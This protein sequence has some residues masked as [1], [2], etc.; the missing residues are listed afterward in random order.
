ME[1]RQVYIILNALKESK[2]PSI[3]DKTKEYLSQRQL[4]TAKSPPEYAAMLRDA[5]RYEQANKEM[6]DITDKIRLARRACEDL[7]E[8]AESIFHWL[9]TS[10]TNLKVEETQYKLH[11]SEYSELRQQER[12]L[13]KEIVKL[14]PTADHSKQHKYIETPAGYVAITS[15][16]K[17][18][19]ALLQ[20]NVDKLGDVT[21][22]DFVKQTNEL[23]AERRRSTIHHETTR[24]R[25]SDS[26]FNVEGAII[27]GIAGDLIDDGTINLSGGA[28]LGGLIG[29]LLSDDDD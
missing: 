2:T 28:L 16:G 14:Q 9:F 10:R 3:D 21:Y 25:K 20:K 23:I 18:K 4:L 11:S 24:T 26:G 29:G 1:A 17:T 27:G 5:A 19:L 8:K 22:D 6:K 7:E 15:T 13:E 12:D